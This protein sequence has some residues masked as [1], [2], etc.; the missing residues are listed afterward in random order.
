MTTATLRPLSLAGQRFQSRRSA[1]ACHG[2][3]SVA[4][5]RTAPIGFDGEKPHGR[6]LPQPGS[7]GHGWQN[8]TSKRD[9]PGAASLEPAQRDW[10][11]L[12]GMGTSREELAVGGLGPSQAMAP[13]KPAVHRDK[14]PET[15]GMIASFHTRNR[16][17]N[18]EAH[19]VDADAV[20]G[21]ERANATPAATAKFRS[22]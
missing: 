11:A 10:N 1:E 22:A 5:R 4:T 6:D 7:E 16:R 15:R 12:K 8:P 9:R 17:R 21:S 2:A 14:S 3:F 13:A 20:A 18:A 19:A